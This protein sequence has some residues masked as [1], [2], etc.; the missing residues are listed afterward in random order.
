VDLCPGAVTTVVVCGT[1]AFPPAIHILPGCLYT[2][3]GCTQE[4]PAAQFNFNPQNWSYDP[5]LGCWV[6]YIIGFTPG[7]ACVCFDRWLPVELTSFDAVGGNGSVTLRWSTASERNSDRFEILRDGSLITRVPAMGTSS[8]AHN[9]S[10]TD[11]TVQ[12]G[13]TYTYALRSV[14]LN[15]VAGE[16]G[17]VSATPQGQTAEVTE[18]ALLQ[19]YPNPFNPTTQITFDVAESGPVTLT[20]FNPMGQTVTKLVDGS[21][22]AGRHTVSFDASNLPTGVYLYRLEAGSFTAVR[23]MLL[24]K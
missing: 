19:N 6:N 15:G 13:V 24:M 2:F 12:N 9:Y 7:C 16:H 5:A 14:D 11:R 17:T 10:Y 20:I 3:P 4:C 22:T 18:F 1:S 21:M 23:K 8:S